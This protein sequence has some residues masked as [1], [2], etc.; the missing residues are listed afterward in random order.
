MTYTISFKLISTDRYSPDE[1]KSSF[2][3]EEM[4]E[5]VTKFL[6]LQSKVVQGMLCGDEVIRPLFDAKSIRKINE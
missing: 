3:E 6:N 5:E 2:S 1:I 4:L